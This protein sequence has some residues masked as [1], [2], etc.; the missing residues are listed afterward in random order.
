M[1]ALIVCLAQMTPTTPVLTDVLAQDDEFAVFRL[2]FRAELESALA[3]LFAEAQSRLGR[4][5]PKSGSVRSVPA[6]HF[7]SS[8][9]A[10]HAPAQLPI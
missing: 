4:P 1:H 8:L 10:G 7:S 2:N 9:E 5:P 3:T 6:M